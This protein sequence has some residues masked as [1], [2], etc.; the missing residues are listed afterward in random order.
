MNQQLNNLL[1]IIDENNESENYYKIWK[2]LENN[3]STNMPL[4]DTEVNYLVSKLSKITKFSDAMYL[5]SDWIY[6]S[7]IDYSFVFNLSKQQIQHTGWIDLF[8]DAYFVKNYFF[9]SKNLPQFSPKT[10]F[11]RFVNELNLNKDINKLEF[12][13]LLNVFIFEVETQGSN[14]NIDTLAQKI[15]S[16]VHYREFKQELLENDNSNYYEHFKIIEK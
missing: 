4:S 16:F 6:E 15:S 3:F 2:K 9:K 14:D 12:E 11:K 8:E 10:H 1:Y 7:N 5:L 13:Y